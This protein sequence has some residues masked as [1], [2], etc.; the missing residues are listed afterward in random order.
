MVVAAVVAGGG[1]GVGG[2][3]A[4]AIVFLVAAREPGMGW[5]RH[6]PIHPDPAEIDQVLGP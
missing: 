6:V 3:V 2:G 5:R 1:G 4:V